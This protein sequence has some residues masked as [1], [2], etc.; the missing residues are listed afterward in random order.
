M[1]GL[2]GARAGRDGPGAHAGVRL[3]LLFSIGLLGFCFER[4]LPFVLMTL[5]R[6]SVLPELPSPRVSHLAPS[7][8]FGELYCSVCT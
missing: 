6:L 3:W 7:G 5:M 8:L 2:T 4:H 1:R